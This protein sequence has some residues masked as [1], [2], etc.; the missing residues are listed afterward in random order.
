MMSIQSVSQQEIEPQN[1]STVFTSIGK[2]KSIQS[3]NIFPGL[4]PIVAKPDNNFDSRSSLNQFESNQSQE[5]TKK[6][7]SPNN[8]YLQRVA[9]S[10]KLKQI[11]EG[12]DSDIDFNKRKKAVVQMVDHFFK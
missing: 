2:N 1:E 3:L 5:I 6:K 8:R 4:T 11:E 10:Q 12:E 7:Q 9:K